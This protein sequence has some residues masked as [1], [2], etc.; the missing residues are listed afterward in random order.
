VLAQHVRTHSGLGREALRRKDLQQA[1]S[2]FEEALLSPPNLSEAKHLLANQSDI[3]YW[4]GVACNAM[5]EHSA[6]RKHWHAA[7]VFQGD[8]QGMRVQ[9]FSEISYFSAL[10]WGHLG[11]QGKKEKLLRELLAFAQNLQKTEAKIDYFATS[12]PTMLLFEDDIQLRQETTALL[13]QAQARLGLGQTIK[14]K[15]LFKEV[16]KRDPNNAL[17]IEL[18][19]SPPET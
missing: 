12:L 19:N 13:L 14:A 9:T 7:A 8:F 5:G 6:A 17:A 15:A 10:A 1:R 16:L 18:L 2:S 3:H 4:L 11:Q